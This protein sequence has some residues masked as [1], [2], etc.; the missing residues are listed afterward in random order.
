MYQ[1]HVSIFCLVFLTSF[2][3]LNPKFTKIVKLSI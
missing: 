3:G 2:L 1:K